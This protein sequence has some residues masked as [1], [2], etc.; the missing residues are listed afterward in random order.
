VSSRYRGIGCAAGQIGTGQH[1]WC[2]YQGR[3]RDDSGGAG[4]GR[5]KVYTQEGG[6]S[7]SDDQG[8]WS[9]DIVRFDKIVTH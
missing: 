4:D 5:V 9:I 3:T 6:N 1:R 8:Y 2:L 7:S